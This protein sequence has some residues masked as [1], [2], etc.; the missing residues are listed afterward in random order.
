V[1]AAATLPTPLARP[2]K[3]PL[4]W[5]R[6]AALTTGIGVLAG[7]LIGVPTIAALYYVLLETHVG[8]GH[9][10][11]HVEGVHVITQ[12]QLWHALVPDSA[13]RH[14]YR[15]VLEGFYGGLIG[16]AFAWNHYKGKAKDYPRQ[17]VGRVAG[18]VALAFVLA[19]P[20]FFVGELL[21][22]VFSPLLHHV[23]T[24]G[25]AHESTL[26]TIRNT[27]TEFLPAKIIGILSASFFGRYAVRGI[28]DRS[29]LWFVK[30]RH[31]YGKPLRFYHQLVP[32]YAA[33]YNGEASHS[34]APTTAASFVYV[35]A[36]T[37]ILGLAGYGWYVLQVIAKHH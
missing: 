19:V 30:R 34:I 13:Q 20:G 15:A 8:I 14:T 27:V 37:L 22:H 29:Q 7:A 28:Y 10:G 1:S 36:A 35:T 3:H 25:A 32:G 18:A 5:A 17:N 4:R 9:L 26:A 31:W 6:N 2:T 12:T 21:V 24:E 16:H 11:I 23:T 33:R